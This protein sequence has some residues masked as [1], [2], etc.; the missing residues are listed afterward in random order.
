[1][2]DK[3]EVN[4]YYSTFRV[5]EKELNDRLVADFAASG[6]RDKTKYLSGL[7]ELGLN[8]KRRDST[9]SN[10]ADTDKMSDRLSRIE[11]ILGE[12]QKKVLSDGVKDE[13]FRKILCNIYYIVYYSAF[14]EPID[15]NTLGMGFWDYLPNRLQQKLDKS[16]GELNAA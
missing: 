15:D 4:F 7:I 8:A 10:K 12:M 6:A 11:Q 3:K 5:Y 1:M 9:L 16:I 14:G 13:V 2:K